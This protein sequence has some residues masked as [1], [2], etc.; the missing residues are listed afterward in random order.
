MKKYSDFLSLADKT[1]LITGATR[2]IGKAICDLF[3]DKGAKII[4]TGTDY[5]QIN[6]LNELVHDENLK[7]VQVDF[8]DDLSFKKFIDFILK[9]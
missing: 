9:Q 8:S 3:L 5:K 6:S 7:Y 2:G 4:A 1:V